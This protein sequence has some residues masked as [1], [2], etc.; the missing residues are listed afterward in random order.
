M[1]TE[2]VIDRAKWGKG[3]LLTNEG[4]M[5]CL[6]FL[7]VAC[8]YELPLDTGYPFNYW[9]DIDVKWRGALPARCDAGD[10][11]LRA[12]TINDS[13][14][15]WADKETMLIKLFAEDNIK[16]SFVGEHMSD[17]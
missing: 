16:L 1:I 10:F 9:T 15:S 3:A 2:L 11:A 12:S 17:D 4:K 6:G 5:C 13:D 14:H 8:G 7:S